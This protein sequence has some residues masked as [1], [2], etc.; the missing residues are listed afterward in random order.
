MGQPSLGLP[1]GKVTTAMAPHPDRVHQI[2]GASLASPTDSHTA[3]L[4]GSAAAT[5]ASMRVVVA[6][7]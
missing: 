4:P 7:G 2:Q 6:H 3:P 5:P 1:A